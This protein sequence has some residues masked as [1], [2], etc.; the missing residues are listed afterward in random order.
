MFVMVLVLEIVGTV[1]HSTAITPA[2][3]RDIVVSVACPS[4]IDHAQ[5]AVDVEDTSQAIGNHVQFV[6]VPDAGVPSAGVVRVGEVRVLFVSVCAPVRVTTSTQFDLTIPD[7][8]DTILKSIFVS[9]PVELI[10][11]HVH[12]AAL[13]IVNSF[14]APDTEVVGNLIS[15]LLHPSFILLCVAQ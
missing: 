10:V 4:S 14:T 1:T 8:F 13:L 7:P 9:P 3:T 2:D 12:V 5:I 15:S 6:S 11:G